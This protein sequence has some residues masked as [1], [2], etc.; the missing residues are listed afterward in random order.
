MKKEEIVKNERLEN[1][2]GENPYYQNN[3]GGFWWR[4]IFLVAFDEP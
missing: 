4:V 3:G 2:M 1:V